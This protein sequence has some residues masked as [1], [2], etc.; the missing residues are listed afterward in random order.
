MD[1]VN[2]ACARVDITGAST[3]VVTNA[4][5]VALDSAG[6]EV[7]GVEIYPPEIEVIIPLEKLPPAKVVP[8]K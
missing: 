5:L 7:T 4:K 1:K 3:E 6:T 2:R 8:F